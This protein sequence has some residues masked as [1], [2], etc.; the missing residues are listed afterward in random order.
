VAGQT[1]TWIV[2]SF[3]YASQ[4]THMTELAAILR[5]SKKL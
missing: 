3:D 2:S 5:E 4:A 1:H